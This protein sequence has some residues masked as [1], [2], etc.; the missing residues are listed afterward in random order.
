MRIYIRGVGADDRIATVDPGVGV[1]IDGVYQART[2][3]ENFDLLDVERVEVLRGPHGTL[4][5]RNT[6][7][8]AINI[9]TQKPDGDFG[10]RFKTEVGTY[11]LFNNSLAL[12][13][14]VV[15]DVLSARVALE[16]KHHGGY[17]ENEFSGDE[18][19]SND[20]SLNGRAQ[21]RWI[22]SENLETTLSF[23]RNYRNAHPA[24]ANPNSFCLTNS[25]IFCQLGVV[26]S[27]IAPLADTDT[28]EGALNTGT[29]NVFGTTRAG[30]RDNIV[31][32]SG[33]TL[34]TTYDFGQSQL[35][36][37]AGGRK[38]E[39][40]ESLDLDGGPLSF[41][42]IIDHDV[43]TQLSQELQLNSSLLENRLEI[44]SGL[45]YFLEDNKN[46]QSLLIASDPVLQANPLVALLSAI[47]SGESRNDQTVN[48][49]AG[50]LNASYDLLPNLTL[51]A[52]LRYSY[53][54]KRFKRLD[55]RRNGATLTDSRDTEHFSD[56]SPQ[57]GLQWRPADELQ[58]YAKFSRAFRG[59][60]FNG[61]ANGTNAL[62]TSPFDPE[63]VKVTEVG[64]KSSF[65]DDRVVFNLAGFYNLFDDLQITTFTFD[66]AQFVSVVN[67]AGKARILGL[68]AEVFAQPMEGLLL[69][70]G[71]GTID[72]EYLTYREPL[73]SLGSTGFVDADDR[74]FKNTPEFSMSTSVAYTFDSFRESSTTVRLDYSHRGEVFYNA[75]NNDA[76][77]QD[78]VGLLNGRITW[79]SLDERLELGLWGRNL[80]NREW[81]LFGF[82][83]DASLGITTTYPAP[84]RELGFDLTLRY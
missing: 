20:R 84:P 47:Q 8:G 7:G 21:L 15:E 81:D 9:V 32:N 72:A 75:V 56:L 55:V 60:G 19:L 64:L 28:F 17:F 68:E 69:T 82:D 22:V 48:T 13:F 34:T 38:I 52:G 29:N 6:T 53:D 65:L 35:K 71:V 42:E 57:I 14:P 66:G 80:T 12:S 3:A 24:G 5:G 51:D 18:Q 44:V 4:Y 11:R 37:I 39:Q 2:Y 23:D 26:Q 61:R 1:Y 33:L 78:K 43:N 46:E 30:R 76:I 25:S 40:R 83:L 54:H 79:R 50:Y 58:L 31:S 59:G 62:T 27:Q 74:E 77:A 16:S 67:N 45:Y 73:L 10:V 70:A 36:W 41:S 49:Y 63:T